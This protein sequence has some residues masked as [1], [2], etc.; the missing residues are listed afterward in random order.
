MSKILVTGASG[1]LG[2][3][4]CMQNYNVHQ[5]T[6]IVNRNNLNNAPF[7]VLHENLTHPGSIAELIDKTRP[8]IVLH[9][10]A[11]AN[12]DQCE[13]QPQSA[14]QIN[15]EV[16]AEFAYHT[17]KNGIKL[18]HISTDAVFDG[19][20]GSYVESDIPNPLGVYART[21]LDGE[22][23]VSKENP[24]ALIARVNFYG[25]S[26]NGQRSLSEF[27]FNNLKK[28]QMVMGFTDVYF[29]P[30][31][32]NDLAELL[33]KMAALDLR[34]I[35]HT[36]SSEC[37]SKFE[38]G[39]KIAKRFELD[40]GLIRPT[41]V[42]DSGLQAVRSQNLTMATKKLSDA[43]DEPLPDQTQSINRLYELFQHGYAEDIYKLN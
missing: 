2:V 14:R 16:P 17:K 8:D 24:E 39:N 27:F 41:R 22:K 13:N 28:K 6:A 35:Y 10:A 15:S 9:C 11:M 1:L 43:L 4:F 20:K 25:W 7:T 12:V 37:I 34:G 5:I 21:K 31:L 26:L 40:T 30:L 36:V 29:C 18:V 3:N 19:K 33:M 42:K 38:F 23:S 32:V